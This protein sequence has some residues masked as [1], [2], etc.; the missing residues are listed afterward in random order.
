PS[1][2]ANRVVFVEYDLAIINA[3]RG[4]QLVELVVIVCTESF[5]RKLETLLYPKT[6][7][8]DIRKPDGYAGD[9]ISGRVEIQSMPT[10]KVF[11][12]NMQ[13]AQSI[14]GNDNTILLRYHVLQS[15]VNW[16]DFGFIT[17][18]GKD[19]RTNLNNFQLP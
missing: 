11:T 14:S 17:E 10:F 7:Q 1:A 6:S 4:P 2:V 18:P 16:A 5:G 8:L 9:P 3:D 13:R 19:I 15:L 12:W